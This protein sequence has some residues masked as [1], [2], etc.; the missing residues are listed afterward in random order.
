[1]DIDDWRSRIDELDARL[2]GLLNQRGICALEIGK[3]KD[4]SGQP[5][6]SPDRENNILARLREAN[7]GPLSD[8]A[9]TRL[10]RHIIDE[11]RQLEQDH[12][13]GRT[14][15]SEGYE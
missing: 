7:D 8:K 12:G 14:A 4:A 10:F 5:I 9:V 13:R 6:Y 11:V 1:M 3:L 15:G 2:L